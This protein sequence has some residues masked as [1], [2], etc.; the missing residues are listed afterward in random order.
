M[1][2]RVGMEGEV[3]DRRQEYASSCEVSRTD[4]S[5]DDG[6]K[7]DRGTRQGDHRRQSASADFDSEAK[8]K[9]LHVP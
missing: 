4:Y 3:G 2:V 9:H 5:K 7:Q 1:R 8:V 6:D